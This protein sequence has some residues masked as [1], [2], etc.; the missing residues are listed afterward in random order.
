[1]FAVM[2]MLIYF[3]SDRNYVTKGFY[4]H[5]S[6]SACPHNCSAHGLCNANRHECR[7]QAGYTGSACEQALCPEVCESNG[8]RCSQLSYKCECPAHRVGYDCGL[9]VDA[10]DVSNDGMWSQL[11]AVNHTNYQSR[12]GHAGVVVNN[13][14]YVY[15]GTTLNTLLNDL[16]YVCVNMPLAWQT[17]GRSQP[18]PDARYGHTMCAVDRQIFMHG[19]V[20]SNGSSSNELWVYD[21]E[22]SGWWLV[23]VS[24]SIEPPALSGH[25]MTVVDGKWLYV[26]GGRTSDGLF[27]SNVYIASVDDIAASGR[28]VTSIEWQRVRSRGGREAHH[29]LVGHTTV[30]HNESQSLLVFGGFSPENARFPRRSSLLL[31]YR[32][33]AR[34]WLSL[35]YDTALPSVPRERAYH[36]A[37]IVGNYMIIHG[38]QVHV[39]H[40]DETCYDFQLYAY[41]LSCHVWVDFVSLTNVPNG[42]W[43]LQLFTSS[44][45]LLAHFLLIC[46]VFCFVFCLIIVPI[47]ISGNSHGSVVKLT[48]LHPANLGS[49]TIATD[50]SH[51]WQQEGHPVKV[52]PTHQKSPLLVSMSS[53]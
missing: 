23:G 29:R 39:H 9:V 20:L 8:G 34:R 13:C 24:G 37:V 7:C 21:T 33:D 30:F 53:P 2:Q 17:V 35:S 19:G 10:A 42:M 11:L 18:W 38:G 26:I 49:A 1:M 40:R 43:L 52:A 41:H 25:T 4:A 12:A 46:T 3:F 36:T 15:G 28:D 44:F 51:W 48:D 14:L 32:V 16:V 31:S 27:V 45:L 6:V 50:I 22:L 5:Y 47:V